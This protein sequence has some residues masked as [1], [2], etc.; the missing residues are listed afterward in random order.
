MS[1]DEGSPPFVRIAALAERVPEAQ[2]ESSSRRLLEG[3]P[4]SAVATAI[5][6]PW[7]RGELTAIMAVWE[8]APEYGGARGL[9]V[10]LRAAAAA[11]RANRAARRL[12]LVW[13]G[14]SSPTGMLRR[15]DQ[16]LLE[17]IQSARE[18]LWI[19]SFACYKVPDIRKALL[20]AAERGVGVSLVLESKEESEG[21][22]TFSALKGLGPAIAKRATVY[23]WPREARRHGGSLEGTLHAKCAVADE[24]LLFVSS[25]N[26]TEFA[27]TV[28][29]EL[30][31]L[32]RGE[33]LP[34]RTVEHFE[35]LV[36]HEHLRAVPE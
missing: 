15:T 6:D 35:W 14:P 12:E 36:R 24:D 17:V 32:I 7:A 25:A 4:R 28:N 34:A 8:R 11:H 10:A 31:V 3:R 27:M 16:A 19:V 1:A 20:D 29:M 2:I 26:L 30:G 5:A 18:S 9:G 23:A 22:L 13:T 33:P 21:R